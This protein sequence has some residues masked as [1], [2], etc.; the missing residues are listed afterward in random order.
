MA[1]DPRLASA[2][3]TRVPHVLWSRRDPG[4][5][6]R[7]PDPLGHKVLAPDEE[8]TLDAMA[9]CSVQLAQ[10]LVAVSQ[11]TRARVADACVSI[12][13]QEPRGRC[14]FCSHRRLSVTNCLATLLPAIAREIGI[15]RRTVPSPR[16]TSWRWHRAG[17]GGNA[18]WATSGKRLSRVVRIEDPAARPAAARE[19]GKPERSGDDRRPGPR[20][21]VCGVRAG[22]M[23][24]VRVSKGWEEWTM[25]P[26]RVPGD[27][28]R[29]S[30]PAG[31]A[32]P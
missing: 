15:R 16:A 32:F 12:Q 20:P 8:R 19:P 22:G 4:Y 24:S 28:F 14:T 1:G 27:A 18:R 5:L 10:G 11:A 17:F 13:A 3:R 29:L 2:G 30:L 9:G 31:E 23:K 7:S 25:G 26:G 6:R 21:A